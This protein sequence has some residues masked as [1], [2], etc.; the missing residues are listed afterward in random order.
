M[1]INKQESCHE[2]CAKGQFD[3][4]ANPEQLRMGALG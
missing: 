3:W 1:M 2:Y 4:I